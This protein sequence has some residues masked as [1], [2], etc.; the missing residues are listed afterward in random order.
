VWHEGAERENHVIVK[1]IN[2]D[3]VLNTGQHA[4]LVI[5]GLKLNAAPVFPTHRRRKL[6]AT[7][8]PSDPLHLFFELDAPDGSGA[9]LCDKLNNDSSVEI[10]YLA[11]M[12]AELPIASSS[13]DGHRRALSAIHHTLASKADL[14][15]MLSPSFVHLQGYRGPAPNGFDFDEAETYSAGLGAG[16]TVAD[17]EYGANIHHEDL[18]MSQAEQINSMHPTKPDWVEHGTAVWGE[19]K[20]QNNSLGVRGGA[21]AVTPIV[22]NVFTATGTFLQIAAVIADTAGHLQ[23]GIVMLIEQQEYCINGSGVVVLG[24]VECKPAEWAA[25]RAAVD[26]GIVV[27]EAGGNG[28]LDLDAVPNG[29]FN[30]SHANFSDSGAIMVG[31][32][33]HNQ[34]T[35]I[36]SSFG[37]RIDVQ[38][39]YDYSV[40]TTG[41]VEAF[42]AA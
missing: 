10:A 35:W 4:T 29:L 22:A 3:D 7:G 19:I 39:W 14:R 24:P 21:V 1:L 12:P 8:E 36:G 37:S 40:T 30:R 33:R 6:Q 11:S 9:V 31:G 16:I 41:Y 13:D 27:V 34:R 26:K 23:A 17:V 28:E 18:N 2:D 25:I 20:G 32:A 38:G 5:G 42:K 15:R